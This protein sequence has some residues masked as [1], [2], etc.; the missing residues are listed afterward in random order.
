MEREAR[1]RRRERR[2]ARGSNRSER[3]AREGVTVLDPAL[4]FPFGAGIFFALPTL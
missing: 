4:K 3:E 1:E 2:I